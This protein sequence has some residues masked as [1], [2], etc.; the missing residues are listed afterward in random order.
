MLVPR[1]VQSTRGET[2]GVAAA[3]T[4]YHDGG[5]G[6]GDWEVA[7]AGVCQRVSGRSGKPVDAPGSNVP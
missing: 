6:H 1:W 2:D 3:C 7:D 5:K 4:D